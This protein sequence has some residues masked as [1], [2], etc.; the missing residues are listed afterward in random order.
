MKFIAPILILST[1]AAALPE[2]MTEKQWLAHAA[3]KGISVV[4]NPNVTP[5]EKSPL[6]KRASY[7]CSGTILCNGGCGCTTINCTR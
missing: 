3:S 5:V 4:A 6:L 7:D 2:A 1:L